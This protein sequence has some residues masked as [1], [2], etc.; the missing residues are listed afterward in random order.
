MNPEGVIG[1]CADFKCFLVETKFPGLETTVRLWLVT[2]DSSGR[3]MPEGVLTPNLD[4]KGVALY[5]GVLQEKEA[6]ESTTSNATLFLI[7]GVLAAVFFPVI[8]DSGGLIIEAVFSIDF[9]GV[10]AWVSWDVKKKI[11]FKHL[12]FKCL[13][14]CFTC[15]SRN[16]FT[17]YY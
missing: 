6:G 11:V 10:E 17:P 7:A 8:G 12:C 16:T 13:T 5:C 2:G 4:R 14:M 1:V 3:I 9:T 15:Y